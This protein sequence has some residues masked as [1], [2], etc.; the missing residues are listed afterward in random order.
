MASSQ[1]KVKSLNISGMKGTGKHPV[2]EIVL[3]EKGIVGD[4]HA[5]A[6]HRQVSLL[7]WESAEQCAQQSGQEIK[8]GDFAENIT[9]TGFNFRQVAI[10]DRIK[11]DSIEMEVTQLGKRCRGDGCAIFRLVGD[12]IMP[13]EGIF[14]RVIKGG[15]LK[16]GDE[17]QFEPRPFGIRIITLSDRASRSDYEDKSGPEI[18]AI[19]EEFFKDKRWHINIENV[20]LPDDPAALK[21]S[22]EDAVKGGA[23]LI[24][25]TGGTG[26]GPRDITPD[27]VV[28]M[29]SKII[30]GIMESIRVKYGAE[31]PNALLSRSV[32]GIIGECLIYT[33]PGSV[34]AVREYL[35]E[36]TKTLEHLIYMV[37]ELDIH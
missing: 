30:P 18:K 12:C 2:P 6:W 19:L 3:D 14:C 27:V 5:G 22:I 24:I 23:D 33:L 1:M 8:P 13:K 25:T 9:A 37:H 21:K 4:A 20:L 11:T 28:P 31:K 17:L 7:A 36:I 15:R 34:R 29:C 10:L 35:A 16:L 26:V 32:A